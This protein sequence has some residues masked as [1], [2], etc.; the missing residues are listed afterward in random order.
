RYGIDPQK[1]K[2]ELGWYPET[3]FEVGIEKTIRWYL[4]NEEWMCHV[5]SGDYQKYY[6]AMYQNK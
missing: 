1:I 4:A 5:T 6:A 2:D 3:T